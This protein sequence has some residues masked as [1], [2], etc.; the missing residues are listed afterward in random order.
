MGAGQMILL[1]PNGG[2]KNMYSVA[3]LLYIS[4]KV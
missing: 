1:F 3:H 4:N 2:Y